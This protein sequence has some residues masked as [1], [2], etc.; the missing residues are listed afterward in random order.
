MFCVNCG[1]QLS[2]DAKFCPSCGS[3]VSGGNPRSNPSISQENRI[4]DE[5]KE[6][7]FRGTDQFPLLEFVLGDNSKVLIESGAMIYH[8]G[9]VRLEGKLNNNGEKGV[10]GVLKAVGRSVVS[11]ETMFITE[12]F[13][14]SNEGHITIAPPTEGKIIS[15]DVGEKQWYLN[16]GVF[17]ASTAGVGYRMKRQDLAK[18]LL[19]GTGGL[20]IQETHGKGQLFISAYG[21][22]EEIDFD[23]ASDALVIDNEHVVAWETSLDY[24][25]ETASGTVGIMSGEGVVTRFHG[26]GKIYIQT[27]SI[28]NLS[29]KI[30][31][32]G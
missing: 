31:A 22:I 3:N 18:G 6:I 2:A 28:G 27:R 14:T 8:N 15:L 23:D 32:N 13:G 11:G 24:H 25:L 26:K 10:G 16:D 29:Q 30:K 17:L 5:P 12:V 4:F 9:N 19:G 21:D 7:V 1:A 20:F